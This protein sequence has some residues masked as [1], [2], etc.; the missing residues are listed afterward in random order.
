MQ[1]VFRMAVLGAAVAAPV[2]AQQVPDSAFAPSIARPAYALGAGPVVAVDTAHHNFHTPDGRY[3]PFAEL[4]RRD[5]FLVRANGQPWTRSSLDGIGVLVVANAVHAS[6]ATNWVLPTPSAFTAEE[7]RAVRQWVERGGS[8]LLI[9]DHM[10]FAG[11]ATELGAAFGITFTNGFA[12]DTTLPNNGTPMIFRR[13]ANLRP[14]VIVDG[15]GADERV[16]SV[17]SFTGSAFRVGGGAAP[18]MVL[19]PGARSFEPDTAWAIRDS[20]RRVD[21]GGWMQGAALR[22]GRGRVAVF[23]EAA[24]FSAQLGGPNRNRMGMNAPVAAQNPQFLLNVVRWLA[25]VL[26]AE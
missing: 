2:A 17:A 12:L 7:I 1:G 11:A 25:G 10:P 21:V 19:G 18:I 3:Y 14:H 26:P 15:R 20:T 23:G 16:D 24:M 4:L 9:A 22:V 6:N 5:G 8:L 13:D